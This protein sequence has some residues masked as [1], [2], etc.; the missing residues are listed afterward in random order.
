V[1]LVGFIIKIH[2]FVAAVCH[3]AVFA[4]LT[5]VPSVVSS[6]SVFNLDSDFLIQPRII[7]IH[8]CLPV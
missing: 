7:R 5:D 3:C 4:R 8:C 6:K 1:H 2:T